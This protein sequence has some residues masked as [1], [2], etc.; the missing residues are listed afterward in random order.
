M[1]KNEM[2]DVPEKVFEEHRKKLIRKYAHE[3]GVDE[4]DLSDEQLREIRERDEYRNPPIKK[5]NG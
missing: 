1:R 3:K 4:N 5:I 2:E